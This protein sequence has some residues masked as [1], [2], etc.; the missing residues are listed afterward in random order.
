VIVDEAQDLH[1]SQWRLLR[2]VAAPGPDDLFFVGDPHQRIYG[3]AA[4]ATTRPA[5]G[6][7]AG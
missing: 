6:G 4:C 7:L 3:A 2:A 5:G 1:P